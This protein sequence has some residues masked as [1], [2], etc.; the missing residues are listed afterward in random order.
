LAI[1]G[2]GAVLEVLRHFCTGSSHKL[3]H[4]RQVIGQPNL[5]T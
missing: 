3:Q 1:E 5:L 4:L 2:K